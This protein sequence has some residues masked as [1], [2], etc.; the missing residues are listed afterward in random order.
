MKTVTVYMETRLITPGMSVS[1]AVV[2]GHM[3]V[4]VCLCFCTDEG[5]T[6]QTLEKKSNDYIKEAVFSLNTSY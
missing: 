2:L 4:C 6:R 1:C 5:G 3:L